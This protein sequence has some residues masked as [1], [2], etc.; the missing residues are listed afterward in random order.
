[1]P[2]VAAGSVLVFILAIGAFVTP[3]LIGGAKILVM[4]ML[5]FQ[6]AMGVVNWPFAAAI[7]FVFLLFILLLIWLQTRLLERYQRWGLAP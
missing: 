6:Q 2:G 5:V 4:P 7:S 1:M 3:A